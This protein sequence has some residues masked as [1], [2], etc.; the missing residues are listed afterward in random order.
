MMMVAAYRLHV[1]LQCGQLRRQIVHRLVFGFGMLVGPRAYEMLVHKHNHCCALH[2]SV[3]AFHA[4]T[5][6]WLEGCA[7]AGAKCW[8]GLMAATQLIRGL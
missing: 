1:V 2:V 7:E 4:A 5:V 6:L 3:L 8:F